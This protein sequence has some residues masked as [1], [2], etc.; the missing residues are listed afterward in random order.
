MTM[1]KIN[2]NPN[3]NLNPFRDYNRAVVLKHPWTLTIFDDDVD[4]DVDGKVW[5]CA[6]LLEF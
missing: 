4:A 6:R 2:P 5:L 3:A 1:T